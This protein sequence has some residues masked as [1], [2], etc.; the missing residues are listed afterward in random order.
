MSGAGRWLLPG[1]LALVCAATFWPVRTHEFVNWDDN[2][3]IHANPLLA[4]GAEGGLARIW[5]KPYRGLYVP[6]VYTA[7]YATARLGGLGPVPFHTLNLAL[8]CLNV[9]LAFL[10]L[11]RLV[12]RDLAAAAGAL[13]FGLHPLQVEPVAWASGTKDLLFSFFALLSLLLYV[14]S[15]RAAGRGRAWVRRRYVLATLCFV[16]S[17]LS[18]PTAVVVPLLAAVLDLWI[19]GRRW[20]HTARWLLPWFALAAARA[21][22]TLGVQTTGEHFYATPIHLRPLVVGDALAF[23]VGKL[24]LPL[25]LCADYGRSPESALARG[26]IYLTWLVPFAL[27]ALA[28]RLRRPFPWGLAAAAIFVAGLAPVSGVVPFLYQQFSTVADRYAYL[29]LVGIGLLV[30]GLLRGARPRTF[31][32]AALLLLGLAAA[33]RA[34]IAHWRDSRALFERALAVNPESAVAHNNLGVLDLEEERV[35]EAIVH[36]EEAIRLHPDYPVAHKNLAIAWMREGEWKRARRHLRAALD[37]LPGYADLHFQ[38]GRLHQEL[39]EREIAAASYRT[40]LELDPRL[41]G[42]HV[43]LG[44]LLAEG[45]DF[46]AAEGHF[47]EALRSDPRMVE[48]H[49]NLGITLLELGSA[50]EA[51]AHLREALRLRPDLTH[52][53]RWVRRAEAAQQD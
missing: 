19:L 52:L 28:W 50:G 35:A 37:V 1:L 18:K 6:M 29:P 11:R 48:A 47:R 2:A 24:A 36:L 40:A 39:G 3:N 9:V 38:W 5:D 42:A 10:L 49:A 15:V 25:G 34:Q 46:A 32:V 13:L 44:R 45:G 8:H 31:A 16:L 41:A 12:R 14:Q 51:L 33:S 43:N 30:A 27:A 23:Y 7:W 17:L 26:S 20:S 21:L 4:E 22:L 53:E